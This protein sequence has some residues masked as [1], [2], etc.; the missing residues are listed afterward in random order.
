MF[1]TLCFP[2]PFRDLRRHMLQQAA[3]CTQQLGGLPRRSCGSDGSL[4]LA[5]Y[6]SFMITWGLVPGLY[7]MGISSGNPGLISAAIALT[8]P[9]NVI[10]VGAIF[11]L[12]CLAVTVLGTKRLVRS[13]QLPMTI[14]MFIGIFVVVA[15]W[16]SGSSQQ[17]S[18][19]LPDLPRIELNRH[20]NLCPQQL[21][22]RFHTAVL[23]PNTNIL[24]IGLYRRLVQHLLECVRLR[25][26]KES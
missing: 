1:H 2:Q 7:T 24:L 21:C 14:I 15:V 16:I 13:F 11:L 6:P 19:V 17:L 3:F 9:V 20:Y 8:H 10:V 23:G 22:P 18:S 5:L 25:G 26:G 4:A 12:I